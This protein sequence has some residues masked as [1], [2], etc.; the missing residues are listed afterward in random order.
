MRMSKS[1]TL[2]ET[3]TFRPFEKMEKDMHRLENDRAGVVRHAR[4]P[5]ASALLMLCFALTSLASL[6]ACGGHPYL[7]ATHK[8]AETTK[9][10]VV[11]VQPIF[12]TAADLCVERANLDYL[13]TRFEMPIADAAGAG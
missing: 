8:F 2:L 11:A 13:R 9:I 7:E 4:L 6:T 10:G 1:I 12:A 3:E 5:G